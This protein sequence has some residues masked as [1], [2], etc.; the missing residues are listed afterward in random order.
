ML[1]NFRASDV[2][3][4]EI[5]IVKL[6]VESALAI[7]ERAAVPAV[8]VKL[9]QQDAFL[10]DEDNRRLGL[11]V[12]YP[13]PSYGYLELPGAVWSFGDQAR[14]R[15]HRAPPLLGQHSFEVLRE[16][17]F[18]ETEIASLIDRGIVFA[19]ERRQADAR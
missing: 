19:G 2:T 16:C 14:L 17:G 3:A 5:A 12:C 18:G 11:S 15:L 1:A 4:L 10:G 13:H 7:A 8:R 9:A 6:D